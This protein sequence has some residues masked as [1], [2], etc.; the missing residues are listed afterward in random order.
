MSDIL[1]NLMSFLLLLFLCVLV[2]F[3]FM[4][5]FLCRY[6]GYRNLHI[7]GIFI[8][9]TAKI[10]GEKTLRIFSS[11]KGLIKAFLESCGGKE[12]GKVMG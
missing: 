4:V 5:D 7:L 12:T 3:I 9:S 6:C 10:S 1:G 8:H 11:K 2:L